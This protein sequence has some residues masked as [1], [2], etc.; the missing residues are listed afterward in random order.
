MIFKNSQLG[1]EFERASPQTQT[2]TTASTKSQR[3]PQI[4]ATSTATSKQISKL[5]Q[6]SSSTDTTMTDDMEAEVMMG[7]LG[8]MKTYEVVEDKMDWMIDDGTN[9]HVVNDRSYFVKGTEKKERVEVNVF[10][11]KMYANMSGTVVIRDKRTEG[12]MILRNVLLMENCK[13]NLISG[14]ILNDKGCRTESD[15]ESKRVWKNNRCILNMR[16]KNRLY[17]SND[18]EVISLSMKRRRGART[19][20]D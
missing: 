16:M 19:A 9:N 15:K 13:Y 14:T 17:V 1:Q 18:I 3:A 12:M 8:E 20:V 2:S 7:R 5:H 11:G 4:H 6:S 10:G